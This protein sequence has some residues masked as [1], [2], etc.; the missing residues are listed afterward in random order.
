MNVCNELQPVYS[1]GL[2]ALL[3]PLASCSVRHP[4]DAHE[5]LV[6]PPRDV[7]TWKGS[8]GACCTAEAP[9]AQGG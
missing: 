8:R 4:V 1:V 3:E 9:E 6:V 5:K 7:K 2:E